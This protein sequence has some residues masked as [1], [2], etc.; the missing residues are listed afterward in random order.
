MLRDRVDGL[1][2]ELRETRRELETAKKE[3]AGD[4]A[5]ELLAEAMRFGE[6]EALVKL[7]KGVFDDL[8][9]EELRELADKLK[10]AAKGLAIVLASTAGNKL[11]LIVSVT[12]D[13]ISRGLHAGK[14][15]K[16]LAAAAGGG[17]GGKA[18]MA[19]AG[20]KDVSKL[21]AVWLA[22]EELLKTF[23][24]GQDN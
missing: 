2:A 7:I 23:S 4:V 8:E 14:L 6:G 17:G 21:P 13:L 22:V 10:A 19:Q 1:L 11:T 18:D 5:V 15:V 12:D 24:N 9:A 3:K 16:K 20:A